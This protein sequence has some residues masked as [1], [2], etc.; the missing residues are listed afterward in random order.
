LAGNKPKDCRPQLSYHQNYEEIRIFFNF[1]ILPILRDPNR[2]DVDGSAAT[3][4]ECF[5]GED[6]RKDYLP[7]IRGGKLHWSLGIHVGRE[8]NYYQVFLIKLKQIKSKK[9]EDNE[10]HVQV[11]P[12]FGPIVRGFITLLM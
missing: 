1:L 6:R 9:M 12:D 7:T 10:D 8:S 3:I 5:Y 4:V 2:N 11:V